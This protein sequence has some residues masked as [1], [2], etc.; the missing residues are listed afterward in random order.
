MAHKIFTKINANWK[1]IKKS[2][3]KDNGSWAKIKKGWLKTNSGWEMIFTAGFPKGI[4][5]PYYSNNPVPT[6]WTEFSAPYNKLILGASSQYPVN[7]SGGSSTITYTGTLAAA[8]SHGGSDVNW[9][10][11]FLPSGD[12]SY[13]VRYDDQHGY[14][15][16]GH[17]HSNITGTVGT[18]PPNTKLRL[19]KSTLE[20]ED[21]PNGVCVFSAQNIMGLP[22]IPGSL[23]ELSANSTF[24]GRYFSGGSVPGTWS[25]QAEHISSA[26][27]TSYNGL[28]HHGKDSI[29]LDT[30]TAGE[31]AIYSGNHNH[32]GYVKGHTNRY[33]CR[34]LSAWYS[35]LD[36]IEATPF[37]IG[38]WEG[39][40]PPVGWV[41]CDGTVYN[42]NG[43][44]IMAPDLRNKFVKFANSSDRNSVEGYMKI[45]LSTFTNTAG[46]HDH[47]PTSPNSSGGYSINLKHPPVSGHSH[48]SNIDWRDLTPVYYSLT[49]IMKLPLD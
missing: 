28:H 14:I 6:A 40:T 8:G 10:A 24:H 46:S 42:I 29:T 7:T 21:L 47:R 43:V 32:L 33:S 41:L 39:T 19:V 26:V 27:S 9:R 12:C 22:G 3:V 13:C 17:R 45:G 36:V 35:A 11:Q 15:A 34:Y 37:M 23:T 44:N 20:S 49:F 1:K 25:G 30:G 5:L 2:W 4:I 31:Y 48:I 18:E 16:G 38:M